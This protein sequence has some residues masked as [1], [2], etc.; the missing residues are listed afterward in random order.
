MPKRPCRSEG[1]IGTWQDEVLL[2]TASSAG[3]TWQIPQFDDEPEVLPNEPTG[4]TQYR[5]NTLDC[6]SNATNAVVEVQEAGNWKMLTTA[7]YVANSACSTGTSRIQA[8]VGLLPGTVARLRVYTTRWSWVTSAMTAGTAQDVT[9][10][11]LGGTTL[12]PAT[13]RVTMPQAAGGLNLS[14]EFVSYKEL[15][16]ESVFRFRLVDRP[17]SVIFTAASNFVTSR[18]V[19]AI[20]A[21]PA[22][23]SLLNPKGEFEIWVRRSSIQ[24][25]L[26]RFE[27]DFY[28][29]VVGTSFAYRIVTDFTWR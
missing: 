22:S 11:N 24:W 5:L 12:T 9:L 10:F 7:N 26:T 27:F 18:G 3:K 15:G 1:L 6:H 16:A 23:G 14:L 4:V 29:Q 20:T 25:D 28:G 13:A 2:C 19:A 8:T 17:T 21:Q